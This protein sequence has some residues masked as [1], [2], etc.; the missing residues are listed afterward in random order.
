MSIED[1]IDNIANQDFAK[2]EP[3]FHDLLN[4]KMND[5][6]EAEKVRVAGQ[7]FNGEEEQ[8]ELDFDEEDLEDEAD[9]EETEEVEDT[10]E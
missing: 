9:V 10:E 5:A 4:A 6:M 8:L 3:M 2:A 1:L 7:I